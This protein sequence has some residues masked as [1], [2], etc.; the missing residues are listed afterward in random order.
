MTSVVSGECLI[1]RRLLSTTDESLVK[2][3]TNSSPFYSRFCEICRRYVSAKNIHCAKCN[4][5]TSKD[6]KTYVHCDACAACVKPGLLFAFP[7]V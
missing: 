3:L 4:S 5:C 2:E 7:Y 1:L 6:G